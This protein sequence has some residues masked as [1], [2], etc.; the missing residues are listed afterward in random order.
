MIETQ[1]D[2]FDTVEEATEYM[3]GP[4]LA[5]NPFGVDFDPEDLVNRLKS[6]E[7]EADIKKRANIGPRGI[8][9]VP[10]LHLPPPVVKDSYEPI[11]GLSNATPTMQKF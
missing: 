8:E 2:N 10:L 1:V 6:G 7:P 9:D 5:E 11:E 4:E 3:T